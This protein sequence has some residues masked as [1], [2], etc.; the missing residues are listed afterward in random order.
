MARFSDKVL[1]AYF[2]REEAA[3]EV[4]VSEEF[5][6][7]LDGREKASWRER[8][9]RLRRVRRVVHFVEKESIGE[10]QGMRLLHICYFDCD[11]IMIN[12]IIDFEVSN[13]FKTIIEVDEVEEEDEIGKF[14]SQEGGADLVKEEETTRQNPYPD[15]VKP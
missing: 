14:Y 9:E 6:A 5:A 1:V 8:K 13:P 4:R 10:L 7:P 2:D 3:E 12:G 15:Q 11:K